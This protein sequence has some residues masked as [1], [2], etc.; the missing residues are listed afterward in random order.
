MWVLYNTSTNRRTNHLHEGALRLTY[1]DHELTLE[2]LLE[3]DGS[4]PIR[5]YNIQT[6]MFLII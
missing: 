4:V 5:Y 6:L 2:K 3:K 1:N